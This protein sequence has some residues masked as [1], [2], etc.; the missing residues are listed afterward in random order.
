MLSLSLSLQREHSHR[1]SIDVVS[2]I[3]DTGPDAQS[4]CYL[5]VVCDCAV[6]CEYLTDVVA[7]ACYDYDSEQDVSDR[8]SVV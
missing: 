5:A 7:F 3:Q 1:D 6:G 2:N 4:D 8:K